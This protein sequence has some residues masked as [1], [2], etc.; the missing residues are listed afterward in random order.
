MEVQL[1]PLHAAANIF[2]SV[3]HVVERSS[4]SWTSSERMVPTGP[5][6]W[7]SQLASPPSYIS[8]KKRLFG[9][10]LHLAAKAL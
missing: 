10:K 6:V 8:V 9:E 7:R 3:E 5:P 4:E 2:P 1:E